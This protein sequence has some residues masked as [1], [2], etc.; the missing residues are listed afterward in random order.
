[1]YTHVRYY[2]IS[3]CFSAVC[4]FV[5]SSC[6]QFS[7]LQTFSILSQMCARSALSCVC[8]DLVKLA[9][10]YSAL[11]SSPF[12][13]PLGCVVYS[14]K[15]YH[16]HTHTLSLV[17][18]VTANVECHL[19]LSWPNNDHRRHV[20]SCGD[21]NNNNKALLEQNGNTFASAPPAEGNRTRSRSAID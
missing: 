19:S 16:S 20:P 2:E 1:M 8:F 5:F 17:I 11:F 4:V 21:Q 18:G 13:L 12:I 10:G 9:H 14:G 3:T 6:W 15:S 7:S